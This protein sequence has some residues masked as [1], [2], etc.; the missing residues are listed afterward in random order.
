MAIMS[1]GNLTS[2]QTTTFDLF[3]VF[4]E[5]LTT[6]TATDLDWT[7][8]GKSFTMTGTGL[9]PVASAGALTDLTGGTL[10]GLEANFSGFVTAQITHWHVSAASWF[11]LFIAQDWHGMLTLVMSGNDQMN[12][13]IGNDILTGLAGRDT[14]FGNGGDD[15]IAGGVGN[16]RLVGGAGNDQLTGGLGADSFV[17]NAPL[18]ASGNTDRI[19]DFHHGQ[20]H[21]LLG[22]LT[23]P[24]LALGILH[25][26][27]FTSGVATTAAQHILY[28]AATGILSYDADGSGAMLARPFAE[29]GAGHALS[30]ADFTVF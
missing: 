10:T 7:A 14:V 23:F 4:G 29:I 18:L 3:F 19:V 16:D 1:F 24:H 11:D 27:N 26:A 8:T 20:D 6:A 21:F 12:G 13:T 5:I 22:H 25:A 2:V 28:D 9:Q 17:F 15:T 30:F